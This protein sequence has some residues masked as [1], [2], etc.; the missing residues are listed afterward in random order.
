[1]AEP[2]WRVEYR[3]NVQKELARIQSE[4]PRGQEAV[5]AWQ[6]YVERSPES[7]FAVPRAENLLSR[8]FHTGVA[9]YLMIYEIDG[10]V[11]RCLGIKPVP[12]GTF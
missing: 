8:P 6:R 12:Y 2:R 11:V 9:A 7:G 1:M 10:D 5:E 4:E 3:A